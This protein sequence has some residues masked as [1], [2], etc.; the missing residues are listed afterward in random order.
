MSTGAKIPLDRALR[1]AEAFRA[2]FKPELFSVWTVAGSVRRRKEEIGDIEHVVI[3]EHGAATLPGQM[4]PQGCVNLMLHR[5]DELVAGGEITRQVKSDGRTR[6]GDRYRACVHGGVVH[7]VFL[8]TPSNYGAI[9][10]IRTGPADWS[11]EMV[12]ILR[13]RGLRQ[14]GGYVRDGAGNAIPCP[15]EQKFFE[16]CGMQY[17]EPHERMENPHVW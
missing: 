13:A 1:Q 5:L 14:E 2:L 8:A 17:I 16:L 7:E 11:R 4:F 10:A 15:T 9:L 3:P 12:T 6:W